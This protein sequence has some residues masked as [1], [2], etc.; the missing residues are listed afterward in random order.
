MKCDGPVMGSMCDVR[1]I[2]EGRG[3][4]RVWG[5]GGGSCV[6]ILYK[7]L[8][9]YFSTNSENIFALYFKSS[10]PNVLCICNGLPI[11]KLESRFYVSV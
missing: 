2:D 4:L 8:I 9:W 7:I 5:K 1:G 6:I 10:K 11:V 3:S